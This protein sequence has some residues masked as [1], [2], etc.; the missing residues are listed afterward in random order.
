MVLADCASAAKS[1]AVRVRGI[2]PP[3]K[4]KVLAECGT[5]I[6]TGVRT[7]SCRTGLAW[8]GTAAVDW[9]LSVWVLVV[10]GSEAAGLFCAA[11]D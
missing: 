10:C 4:R 6:T 2:P 3:T 11:A 9:R 1:L 5:L 7:P 8:V